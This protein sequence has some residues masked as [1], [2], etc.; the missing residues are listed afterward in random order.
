MWSNIGNNE[1]SVDS[2]S[3]KKEQFFTEKN[4]KEDVQSNPYTVATHILVNLF[5]AL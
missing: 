3:G 5:L 2:S 1:R 4:P